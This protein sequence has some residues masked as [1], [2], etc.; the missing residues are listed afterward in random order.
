MKI[1]VDSFKSNGL[2]IDEIIQNIRIGTTKEGV[3][4]FHFKTSDKYIRVEANGSCATLDYQGLIVTLTP[5]IENYDKDI[6]AMTDEEWNEYVN[7]PKYYS[8]N[9]VVE[10]EGYR[11]TST[12]I[13]LKHE[14]FVSFIPNTI[15][16]NY[17]C[18]EESTLTHWTE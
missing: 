12:V 7:H 8:L 4:N 10:T 17:Q 18:L 16:M 15:V 13:P 3:V 2:G 11:Y 14:Y 6:V 5:Y 1:H 9:L